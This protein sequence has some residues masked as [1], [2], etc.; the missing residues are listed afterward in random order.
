[1]SSNVPLEI[2]IDRTVRY[3]EGVM[4]A[5][6]QA[7][8]NSEKLAKICVAGADAFCIKNFGV[9]IIEKRAA[10]SLSIP[11]GP[12]IGDPA[13]WASGA[14]PQPLVNGGQQAQAGSQQAPQQ[15]AQ[16]APPPG[17]TLQN[18]GGV[19][20]LPHRYNFQLD[21]TVHRIR[22]D[23]VAY[24]QKKQRES[25]EAQ[26]YAGGQ[27]LDGIAQTMN[28]SGQTGQPQPAGGAAK[29]AAMQ[30]LWRALRERAIAMDP[31][32]KLAADKSFA[33]K[34]LTGQI[35]TA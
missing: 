5:G 35:R 25:Q 27:G 3:L 20:P 30:G 31:S 7:G 23:Q 4:R 17:P 19:A 18:P 34:V 6:L 12:N 24:A 22:R 32:S 15:Q 21:D 9:P 28:P 8:L 33:T 14:S 10:A 29:T 26:H 16:T 11:G 2:R 1:M 13:S